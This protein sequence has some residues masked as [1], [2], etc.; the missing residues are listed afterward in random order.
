MII[1]RGTTPNCPDCGA[2]VGQLHVVGCDIERCSWCGHQAI[3]C[4][5]S[6]EDARLYPRLPW[7]GTWPG[8]VECREWGW[9]SRVVPGQPGRHRCGPGDQ[10]ATAD[11]LRLYTEARWNPAKGRWEQPEKVSVDDVV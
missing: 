8:V 2:K 9:F 5:C 10:G 1:D 7:S 4:L 11:L 6:V 3:G